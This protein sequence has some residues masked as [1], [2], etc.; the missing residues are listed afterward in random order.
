MYRNRR[1]FSAYAVLLL[2]MVAAFGL[3]PSRAADFIWT[4]GGADGNWTTGGNWDGGVAPTG[5]ITDTIRLAGVAGLTP[6]VDVN[7]PW[8]LN[9][10]YFISG[11]SPFTLSGN[12]LRFAG[13][14]GDMLFNQS[15]VTQTI[16]NAISIASNKT[17][18]AT[19]GHLV[20]SGN[21][22]LGGTMNF[23]GGGSVT[24]NGLI[25]GSAGLSR[26]DPGIVYITND[27]NDFAG[28][29]SIAHG[30]FEV[31]S[32][33]DAGVVCALGKGSTIVLSQQTYGTADA[34]TLRYTGGTA[35]TNRTIQMR[36]NAPSGTPVGRP[37]IEVTNPDTTLTFTGNFEY[38]GSSSSGRFWQLIGAGNGVIEGNITTTDAGIR[39]A[40]TGMWTLAGNNTYEGA[41]T[42]EV[43]ILRVLHNNALG[44]TDGA[45]IVSTGAQLQIA[46]GLTLA[47]AFT[48]S[49]EGQ[50]Y[51]GALRST[52]GNN[53]LTGLVTLPGYARMTA[54]AGTLDVTGGVSGGTGT[55][56]VNANSGAVLRFTTNPVTL[57]E[58]AQ[59]YSDSSGTVVLGVAGNTW[60]TTV[61]AG[62]T[63]RADVANALPANSALSIGL[64]YSPG[65]TFDLNGFNQTVS[66]LRHGTTNVG[67]RTV[68]SATAATLTVN[69]N[70]N[71][72]YDGALTG[73]LALIK[74]GT[75]TLTL[76]G[77]NSHSLA[78]TFSG[79]TLA[80][81]HATSVNPIAG[82]T[83]IDIHSGAF[84]D[85]TGLTAADGLALANGQTLRGTGTLL[86]N[87]TSTSGS[88]LAP[89]DSPGV[90][91]IEGHYAQ[92]SG[93]T[94][95]IEI[96]GKDAPGVDY[97]LLTIHGNASLAG[98]LDVSLLGGFTAQLG[99]YFDVLTTTGSLDIAGMSLTGDLPNPVFGWWD[100]SVV[101]G[102]DGAILRLTAIPEPSAA[103]LAWLA[104][105]G[106]VG[107]TRRRR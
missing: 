106:L 70:T 102:V 53:T 52:S 30:V 85:V 19:S 16:E 27:N 21:I 44:T 97:D 63:V 31:G 62:G 80:L 34:G 43:G 86:G 57:G 93:A 35:S 75:G 32:I 24:L 87:L 45:T 54:A 51:A 56:V 60:G 69:Q 59:F 48:L 83:I 26:T 9:N 89:G 28:D 7:D 107:F 61:V 64:S 47:E 42:V 14:A 73:N 12:T 96:A 29:V 100:A 92:D 10:L 88:S 49:G 11:A 20:L 65:G 72:T 71:S 50:N 90:F 98:W 79:G 84:L 101:G 1:S 55:F 46:G 104:I 36:S 13:S 82:S 105:G 74:S 17:V 2:A 3:Q 23:R 66:E 33:A 38:N 6:V 78:T 15:T 95:A 22:A 25:T 39:K 103:L 91:T 81:S 58:T 99:D 41:T 5:A 4:G 40:G 76:A 77:E 68:T 94:L 8:S 37:T 18:Q 67:T